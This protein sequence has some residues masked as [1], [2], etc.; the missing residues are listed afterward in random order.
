MSDSDQVV[1]HCLAYGQPLSRAFPVEIGRRKTIGMLKKVIKA[2][3]S[4]EFDGFA[5]DHLQLWKVD[6]RL[7]DSKELER[8]EPR[9]NEELSFIIKVGDLFQEDPGDPPVMPSDAG[10]LAWDSFNLSL[11]YCP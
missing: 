11:A 5:A 6:M 10:L 8:F 3:K 1:F 9:D 7:G 2:D 4:P